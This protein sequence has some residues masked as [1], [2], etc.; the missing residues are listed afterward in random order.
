LS[1]PGVERPLRRPD[2]YRRAVGE[3]VVVKAVPGVDPRR[4]KGL[5]RSFEDRALTVEVTEIDGVELSDVEVQTLDLSDVDSAKT[6]FDWGPSP[7]PG[8]GKGKKRNTAADKRTNTKTEEERG[9][10]Q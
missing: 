10:E 4:I 9:H 1:S 3:T 8:K 5:L 2:H 6:H 7:K